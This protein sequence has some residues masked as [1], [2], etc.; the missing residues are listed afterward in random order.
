MHP[1]N[2]SRIESSTKSA[3]STIE[4]E[5]YEKM[6]NILESTADKLEQIFKKR[7]EIT[8]SASVRESYPL[9]L[10]SSLHSE[11]TDYFNQIDLIF[12][13]DEAVTALNDNVRARME[14]LVRATQE[15]FCSELQQIEAAEGNQASFKTDLWK[16]PDVR[17]GAA[18]K[19]AGGISKVLVDGKVFEKAGVSV[20]ISSGKLPKRAVQQMTANHD[21]L[22]T[23]LVE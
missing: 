5:S 11:W 21:E 23:L 13:A 4:Q 12:T 7:S 16:R 17:C 3:S 20:S 9:P 19:Y 10:D 18:S 1:T 8:E 2:E 22:Q 15:H 6:Q 14:R